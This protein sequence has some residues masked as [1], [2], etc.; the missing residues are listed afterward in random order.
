MKK[1]NLFLLIIVFLTFISCA[2][3]SPFQAEKTVKEFI[4]NCQNYKSGDSKES[5]TNLCP[6]LQN[7]SN[8]N[9]ETYVKLIK[10]FSEYKYIV[11]ATKE[12][13]NPV[14]VE[15]QTSDKFGS[16][17]DT[18]IF[19]V[20]LKNDKLIIDEEYEIAAPIEFIEIMDFR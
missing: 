15:V 18:Y 17:S 6:S 16:R 2:Q 12:S 8:E 5:I 14:F 19:K 9:F 3:I 4:T 11:K 1:S 20:C 10:N 7:Y 13:N